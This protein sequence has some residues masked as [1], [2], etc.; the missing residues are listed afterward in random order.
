MAVCDNCPYFSE[1][2]KEENSY[3]GEAW[4]GSSREVIGC[5]RDIEEQKEVKQDEAT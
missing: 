2:L 4:V 1:C 3:A 5:R